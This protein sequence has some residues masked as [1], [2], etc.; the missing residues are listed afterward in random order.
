MGRGRVAK[1]CYDCAQGEGQRQHGSFLGALGLPLPFKQN[2]Y[3]SS[4]WSLVLESIILSRAKDA[5]KLIV[6]NT[7]L[8]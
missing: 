3:P 7:H 6:H 4:T 1:K 8:H 2:E 5:M